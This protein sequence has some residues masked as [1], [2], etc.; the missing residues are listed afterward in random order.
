MLEE[1]LEEYRDTLV[2]VPA[3]GKHTLRGLEEADPIAFRDVLLYTASVYQEQG[4]VAD[5]RGLHNSYPSEF[6]QQEMQ[7]Q[8]RDC[9]ITAVTDGL[10]WAQTYL[11]RIDTEP[12]LLNE[13]LS[14]SVGCA[15]TA[16]D[17]MRE[18][19]QSPRLTLAQRNLTKFVEEGKPKLW[20]RGRWLHVAAPQFHGIAWR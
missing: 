7:Y 14:A 11:R 20:F 10:V 15:R 16:S 18:L 1:D 17:A 4:L 19:G 3:L 5:L 13:H 2:L 6:D 12:A 8:L 9:A